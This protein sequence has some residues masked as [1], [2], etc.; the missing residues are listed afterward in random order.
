MDL[1]GKIILSSLSF[2]VAA[3]FYISTARANPMTTHGLSTFGDLKYA[4]D[5]T[6]FDYVNPEAPKGGAIKIRN[7]DS[8][9][10]LNPF[11]LKGVYELINAD[12][13]GDLTF[14]F[15]SLMTRAY[16]EPDAVYPLVAEKVI[17]DEN[18][19]WVEFHLRD[20]PTFHDGS[21]ITVEDVAY[22]FNTLKSD[23]HPR[24]RLAYAD[25][26]APVI[27]GKRSI[28][29]NFKEDAL[30]RGLALSV[31]KMPIL[32][33]AH[34]QTRSF[35][36]TTLEPIL[37]SGPYQIIDVNPG[38]SVTYKRVRNHWAEKLP[39]HKG[40]YNFDQIQVD[41][42]R[43][44]TIALEAFFAGEYD[45]R[46]EYT[47]KSWANDYTNKPAYENGSV[48]KEV[49]EDASMTGFQAFFFNTRLDKFKDIRVRKALARLFDFEWTNKNLFYGSY[50]RL[51]SIFEN[52]DMKAV[53]PPSTT[54]LKLLTPWKSHIPKAAFQSAFKPDET[55]GDG[56]IRAA[57]RT[58]LNELKEAGWTIQNKQLANADGEQMTI[59]FLIYSKAFE[60]II[61]PFIRNLERIGVTAKIRLVDVASWQNRMQEFDFEIAT[62]RFSQPAFPGVE[63]RNWWQ[64]KSANTI[65]GLN[66]AGVKNPAVDA[67]IEKI[68]EAKTKGQLITAAKA[69]D[70]VIMTSHFTV[71][72]WYKATHFVA[73][74][75]KFGRP[76]AA[77]P[78]FDRAVLDTWWYDPEKVDRLNKLQGN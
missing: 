75:N 35:N 47:S 5:F 6:H 21:P 29:F 68:I 15:S 78:G 55:A 57:I 48:I 11:I 26:L 74:W 51:T 70:R 72:Q 10:S 39:V 20:G 59:E 42:Y 23:G 1:A 40:R 45:F 34:F 41:Y 18:N 16:D 28:R 62:R 53:G 9:D 67:L 19:K 65:G 64:S 43:D 33:K 24:Y 73:Y 49:L 58:S 56:N 77:K 13:G 32:S 52:S 12:K 8:F 4:K 69:L 2:F 54:E 31:A 30:T 17:Q 60:R 63:L 50:D 76:F 27:M 38:R 22:T 66:I 7:L 71:P 36:E 37:G 44:R 25:I 14:N 61:N 3:G 46:E